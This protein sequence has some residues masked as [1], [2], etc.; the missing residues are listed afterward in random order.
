MGREK[1]SEGKQR[2]EL[3]W[4]GTLSRSASERQTVE[5][6]DG[7]NGHIEDDFIA[8]MFAKLWTENLLKN[9]ISDQC[10]TGQLSKLISEDVSHFK[11]LNRASISP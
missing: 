5:V 11:T 10:R 9:V 7:V 8:V 1:V 4:L 3:C 2:G 6:F